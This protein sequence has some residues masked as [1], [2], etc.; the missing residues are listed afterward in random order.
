MISAKELQ[1]IGMPVYRANHQVNG[2]DTNGGGG[3]GVVNKPPPPVLPPNIHGRPEKY[4]PVIRLQ[5]IPV[6]GLPSG[7]SAEPHEAPIDGSGGYLDPE[8]G[9]WVPEK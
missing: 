2:A 4:N 9:D 8:T 1:N 6:S 7:S 3:G 5:N